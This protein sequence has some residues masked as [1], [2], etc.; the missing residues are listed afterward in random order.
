MAKAARDEDEKEIRH[1]YFHCFYHAIEASKS[2]TRNRMILTTSK[3]NAE[4]K[5]GVT[6]IGHTR[7]TSCRPTESVA[8]TKAILRNK[9][10]KEADLG[11]KKNKTKRKNK[12]K[13]NK[14][15]QKKKKQK[16]TKQKKKKKGKRKRKGSTSSRSAK[17][18]TMGRADNC[19]EC[20]KR[21]Y[22]SIND[23]LRYFEME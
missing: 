3:A 17:E 22:T 20:S 13:Q 8:N 6:S 12:K 14:K 15:K 2:C 21:S 19:C 18:I 7:R 5:L 1:H 11:A 4:G 23:I 9:R 16:K 10:G